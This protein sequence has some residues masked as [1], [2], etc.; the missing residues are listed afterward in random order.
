LRSEDVDL[1]I[2]GFFALIQFPYTW[3]F[4]CSPLLEV[5]APV[6]P[7]ARPDADHPDRPFI[8]HRRPER[9]RS[10]AEAELGLGWV[11]VFFLL[12]GAGRAG[13]ALDEAAIN[14]PNPGCRCGVQ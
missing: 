4:L 7:A 8:V 11:E 6:P 2:I 9:V 10:A 13:D 14:F 12:R 5:C 3:R 1:K